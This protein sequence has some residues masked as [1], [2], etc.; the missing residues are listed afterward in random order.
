MKHCE[1]KIALVT[2]AAR[3]MG[4]GIALCLAAEGADVA[5]N[6]LVNPVEAKEV[7]DAIQKIGRRAHYWQ[8]DVADRLFVEGMI[9]EIIDFFGSLDI[10]VA[11]AGISIPEPV[12]QAQW[13]NVL[14][15]IEVTQF[16]VFH[17]CQLAA[18]QMV[19]QILQGKKG[20]KIIIISSVHVELAVRGSAAYNMSKAA[21]TQLGRTLAMEL[22]SY[23][24]NVNIIHPGLTDT[25]GTRS[26]TTKKVLNRAAKRIPWGRLGK[27]EDIGKAVV[28][29]AS[30]DADY[31][32]GVDLRVD[33]G[34]T[35]GPRF[36][37]E[38]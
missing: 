21:V 2:G 10:C 13:Q 11:N 12:I 35:L 23:G 26:V 22:A 37:L 38:D 33:G 28:F 24:I 19:Q 1:G 27:P 30:N 14:R 34:F 20:G 18:K 17:T 3:G 16:G 9:H 31:I 25:P 29:L 4:H 36:P 5:I 32:T 15:T 8:G 6:D 7:I